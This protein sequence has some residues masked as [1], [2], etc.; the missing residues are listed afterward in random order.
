MEHVYYTPYPAAHQDWLAVIRVKVHS[1]INNNVISQPETE[2]PYQDVH[3]IDGIQIMLQ[4][5]LDEYQ[6]ILAMSGLTTRYL[7]QS[8]KLC[9]TWPQKARKYMF[10]PM[11]RRVRV[12]LVIE[13]PA[14]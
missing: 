2:A 13:I 3:E 1:A 6:E 10:Q 9:M 5:D 4:I 14:R 8:W 7:T 12:N 11:T